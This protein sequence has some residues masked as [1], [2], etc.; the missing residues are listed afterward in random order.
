MYSNTSFDKTGL[1]KVLEIEKVEKVNFA[2]FVSHSFGE[3][4]LKKHLL[5]NEWLTFLKNLK[6]R[7][8]DFWRASKCSKRHGSDF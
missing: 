6:K 2:H 1:L 4:V 7:G 5:T 3:N 8:F